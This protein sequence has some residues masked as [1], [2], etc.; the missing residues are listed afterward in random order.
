MNTGELGVESHLQAESLRGTGQTMF[1]L[2]FRNSLFWPY[3]IVMVM[4]MKMPRMMMMKKIV[5]MM[6][7]IMV[8]KMMMML[9]RRR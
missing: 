8:M 9:M 5:M 2:I 3:S 1:E 7:L 4:M 6:M